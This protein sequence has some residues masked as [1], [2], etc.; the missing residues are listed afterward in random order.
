MQLPICGQLRGQARAASATG[1]ENSR[2]RALKAAAK[3][4]PSQRLI[5]GADH[6][7]PA[8]HIQRA[9]GKGNRLFVLSASGKAR[10]DQHQ[11]EKPMVFMA[12]AAAPIL[13]GRLVS[14]STKRR[15]LKREVLDLR[16]L[17]LK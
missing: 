12:R 11:S 8:Q 17:H 4:Q 10:I 6:C 3:L 9:A 1:G 14:T 2:S 7:A 13:P 16:Q 5:D 15:R